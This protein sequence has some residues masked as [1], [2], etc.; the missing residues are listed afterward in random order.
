MSAGGAYASK[1]GWLWPL[2]GLPGG[3]PWHI[4][5]PLWGP[6]CGNDKDMQLLLAWGGAVHQLQ[7][8]PGDAV[9]HPAMAMFKRG[10]LQREGGIPVLRFYQWS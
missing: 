5:K 2:G 4:Q 10:G 9:C 8:W 6:V 1:A 7:G 3:E